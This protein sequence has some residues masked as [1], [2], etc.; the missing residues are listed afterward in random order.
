MFREYRKTEDTKG[1][2]TSHFYANV[3][4]PDA[5]FLEWASMVEYMS[6]PNP[7]IHDGVI[8]KPKS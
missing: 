3:V 8:K 6:N 5:F 1:F 7:A 2:R 4:T